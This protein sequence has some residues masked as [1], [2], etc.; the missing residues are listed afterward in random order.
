MTSP[1]TLSPNDNEPN[2]T[3]ANRRRLSLG[4]TMVVIVS[5]AVVTTACGNARGSPTASGRLSGR[6]MLCRQ[7]TLDCRRIAVAT[8]TAL[9]VHGT[10]FGAAIAKR[11]V[12]NGQFSFSLPEGKY[13]PSASAV[14][15]NLNG[16]H[17]IAG[18][19]VVHARQNVRADIDCFIGISRHPGR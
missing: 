3:S 6:I 2:R 16:G 10:K 12:T 1:R 8:V 17:C 11:H 13:F 14:H 15:A 4:L 5:V 18:E 9:S 7:A 19:V